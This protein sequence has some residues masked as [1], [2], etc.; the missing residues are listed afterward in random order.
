MVLLSFI[1]P[2]VSLF[3]DNNFSQ[4]QDEDL[5]EMIKSGNKSALDYLINRY[6]NL[7][8]IKV[9]K[10]YMIGAEKEDI[11]QEGLIGLYKE[12]KSYTFTVKSLNTS[13]ILS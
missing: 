11:I 5:I 6:K 7:V 9:S 12:I 4:M 3:T 8:N 10:Y 2:T 1:Q 13:C